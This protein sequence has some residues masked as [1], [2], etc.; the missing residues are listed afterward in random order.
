MYTPF[1]CALSFFVVVVLVVLKFSAP[2][3][4][5]KSP[6]VKRSRKFSN[7]FQSNQK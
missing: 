4:D 3:T 1:I 5:A 6:N 7:I 2:L